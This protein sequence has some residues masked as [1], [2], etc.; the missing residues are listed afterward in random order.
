MVGEFKLHT[1][2]VSAGY[3]RK[4]VMKKFKK[5]NNCDLFLAVAPKFRA[6][7][8]FYQ[9]KKGE[10]FNTDTT[11]WIL[12]KIEEG[13]PLRLTLAKTEYQPDIQN[14]KKHVVIMA[15]NKLSLPKAN[16]IEDLLE[17]FRSS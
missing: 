2:P 8:K 15:M 17:E 13:K 16:K 12:E 10:L 6:L 7:K 5:F 3:L 14:A 1:A 4:N 11:L 9:N